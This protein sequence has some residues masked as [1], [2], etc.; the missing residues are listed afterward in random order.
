MRKLLLLLLVLIVAAAA[1]AG[2]IVLGPGPLA[3]AGGNPVA[4]GD[5]KADDPTGVPASLRNA[6][7]V[8]RGE[9]LSRAADCEACHTVKGGARFAGGLAFRLPFGTLY[10]PNITSDKETG[11]GSWSDSD[12]LNA[13]HKG[14][15]PDGTR[16]YPAFPYAAYTMMTD[17]DALAIKAF[18]FSLPAVRAPTLPNTFSFPFNQRWLMAFWSTF[19]NSDRRFMPNP[20]QSPVWNRGAY[21]AEAMAHCGDCHTP[22]N[23]AQ[24][25]DNRQKFAGAVA[26]G[27]KAYDITQDRT[28]GIGSW[29][30]DSLTAFLA[31]GHA[32][33]YGTASGPMGEAVDKSL[34]HLS[35]EDIKALVTYL[36]TIPPIADSDL[37]APK[38]S[39]A[40]ASH[41]EGVVMADNRGKAIFAGACQGCHGWTGESPVLTYATFTGG[42]A[43]ND[44]TARN[45]AQAIVWG[46]TRE[47]P[48]GPVV[49]PAFGH[50]YSDVEIAAVADY[51]TARFGAVPSQITAQ[52]VA[53]IRNEASQ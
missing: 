37:P 24:A 45:V 33:G 20:A 46:V 38:T 22:R 11:I 32:E 23:L 26:A 19:F 40:P 34:M 16:L 30:D 51:V 3:F 7:L 44:P 31:T 39:P 50:A 48:D 53:Q 9:Y 43:V 5:Y 4:L 52:Q 49:M 27:W 12:F 10:A 28:S 1:F 29:S 18:L 15:A 2:W 35:P 6:S 21:L 17:D 25:L 14:V 13:I 41:R 36:R 42:R 47:G 8:A